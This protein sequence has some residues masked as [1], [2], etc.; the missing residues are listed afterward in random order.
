M[1]QWSEYDMQTG[2]PNLNLDTNN[3]KQLERLATRPVTG[4][5]HLS[6]EERQQRQRV[7]V[8]FGILTGVLDVGPGNCFLPRT[9]SGFRGHS[10][11]ELSH[12]W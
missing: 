8:E 4:L 2:S 9:R 5:H 12:G 7:R 3:L 6:H 10:Y 11:K 1:G